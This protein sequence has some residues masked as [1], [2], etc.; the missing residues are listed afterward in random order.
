MPRRSEAN[1]L[2]SL[3][4]LVTGFPASECAME[5]TVVYDDAQTHAW[6]VQVYQK[7]QGILGAQA[8]R[9]TWWNVADLA[10]PGVLAGAVSKAIRSDLIVVAVGCSEGLPLPFYF[11][12]NAWLP[13]RVNGVGALVGLLAAPVHKTTQSGRLKRYLQ[14]VARR[15]RMDWIVGERIAADRIFRVTARFDLLN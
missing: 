15:A 8:V 1:R 6:A 4:K 9:P 7:I 5:I 3:E 10:E 2:G 13:H 14:S 12:V 11:W